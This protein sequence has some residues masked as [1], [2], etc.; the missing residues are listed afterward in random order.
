MDK[1][2]KDFLNLY[3]HDVPLTWFDIEMKKV[4]GID[5]YNYD[6]PYKK[7]YQI[8]TAD[9]YQLLIL[10]HDLNDAIKEKS[11]ADFLELDSFSLLKANEASTKIYAKTYNNFVNSISLPNDYI[12][13]MLDSKYVKHFYSSNEISAIS[14]KWSSK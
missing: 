1:L 13:Q 6:F 2:I 10:K 12:D 4:T 14:S 5:V 9:P 7:G 3:T 11:I 8:I